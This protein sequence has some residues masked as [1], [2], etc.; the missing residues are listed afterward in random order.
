MF[1]KSRF[2]WL[3]IE[4][5]NPHT[6]NNEQAIKTEVILGDRSQLPESFS[7][8]VIETNFTDLDSLE[9]LSAV[10]AHQIDTINKKIIFDFNGAK[11]SGFVIIK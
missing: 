11:P 2:K 3:I 7:H 10:A 6:S 4:P 5:E 1:D 8:Y 9:F